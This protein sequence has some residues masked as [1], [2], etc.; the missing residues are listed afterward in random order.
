MTAPVA[1][2]TSEETERLQEPGKVGDATSIEL[3]ECG[4]DD[5]RH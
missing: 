5:E 4:E 2:S 3:D 1:E